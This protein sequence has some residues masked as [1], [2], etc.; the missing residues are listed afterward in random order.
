[1]YVYAS[2]PQND[3]T[4]YFLYEEKENASKNQAWNRGEDGESRLGV[5]E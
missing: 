4:H 3:K 2:I 1:M 5:R